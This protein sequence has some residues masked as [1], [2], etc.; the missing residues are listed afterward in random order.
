MIL[1]KRHIVDDQSFPLELLNFPNT[2]EKVENFK[3]FRFVLDTLIF[4]K[5]QIKTRVDTLKLM[6][7]HKQRLK[8]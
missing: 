8:I 5:N 3:L 4:M 7:T 2:T 1:F 6:F